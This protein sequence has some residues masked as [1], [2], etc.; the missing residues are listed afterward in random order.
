MVGIVGILLLGSLA[1][2]AIGAL[3]GAAG[4]AGSALSSGN[5]APATLAPAIAVTPS[6]AAPTDVTDVSAADN[7]TPGT[8]A[9]APMA[10]ITPAS[11]ASAT[12]PTPGSA[13]TATTTPAATAPT[14]PTPGAA[15][16]TTAASGRNP[17]IL[18]PLP[19]PGTKVAPGQVVVEARG[20]G[21]APITGIRL[22]LDGAAL[23]V[24]LEQ[25][26]DSTWRGSA[27]T[28]VT[29][30]QHNVRASVTDASGRSGSYR[31]SFTASAASA[32]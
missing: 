18:L 15:T 26:S 12:T 20:R 16:P 6:A 13:T 3:V 29:A 2:S 31:W 32:P 14:T 5:A 1:W 28:H 30:G 7:P 11:T 10:S 4:A 17:W 27:S 9:P 22:E 25:R 23:P 21:D 19:E 24:A 8:P